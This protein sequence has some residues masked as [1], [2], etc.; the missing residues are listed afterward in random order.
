VLVEHAGLQQFQGFDHSFHQVIGLRHGGAGRIDG[1]CMLSKAV[2]DSG[3][4]GGQVLVQG[5]RTVGEI[6]QCLLHIG[7][8][9]AER[10]NGVLYTC[11]DL[12]HHGAHFRDGLT[13]APLRFNDSGVRVS[14]L[15]AQRVYVAGGF[16]YLS[17]RCLV[18]FPQ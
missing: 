4:I 6:L 10:F 15:S 7:N 11:H 3:Q 12:F 8:A 16:L 1:G 2:L 17:E 13:D 9:P 18:L 5:G 14:Q